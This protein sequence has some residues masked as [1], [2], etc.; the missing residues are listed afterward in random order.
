MMVPF[1][2]ISLE[3]KTSNTLESNTKIGLILQILV[4][5]STVWEKKRLIYIAQF[6]DFKS[7]IYDILLYLISDLWSYSHVTLI[8]TIIS[9]F[10]IESKDM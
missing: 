3:Y 8:L 9:N 2:L 5:I 6:I 4:N 1:L 7:Q 10:W